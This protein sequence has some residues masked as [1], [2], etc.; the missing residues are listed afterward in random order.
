VVF[1]AQKLMEKRKLGS[2]RR[3]AFTGERGKSLFALTVGRKVEG[4]TFTVIV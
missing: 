3:A 4:A 2:R 1:K